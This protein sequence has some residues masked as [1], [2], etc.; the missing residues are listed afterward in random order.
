M[1]HLLGLDE[2]L[3][4]Q[5]GAAERAGYRT[6]NVLFLGVV[7]L[8]VVSNGYSGYLLTGSWWGVPW[9]AL[10]MGFIHFSVLRISLITLMTRPLTEKPLPNSGPTQENPPAVKAPR[11]ALRLLP[12]L[13]MAAM[14]RLVFTGLIAL[15]ICMPFAMLVFHDEAIA[16]EESYRRQLVM[17]ET[18]GDQDL[19]V[20]MS[21]SYADDKEA[22][23]PFVVMEQL[24][25]I[26]SYRMLVL[27]LVSLVFL[28]SLFLAR[29]RYGKKYRYSLLCRDAMRKEISLDYN[30]ALEQS[31]YLLGKRFPVFQKRLE[32][33]TVFADPPFNTTL[34]NA[35]GN[36]FG[37][38]SEF[39]NHLRSL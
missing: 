24:W 16:L 38:R 4:K 17:K 13:N 27:F 39:L 29:L 36:T 1:N 33:A 31:Q 11:A 7:A 28:P 23:Y 9:L 34:R 12:R 26:S 5:V 8:S 6:V 18:A 20:G 14:V 30:E 10:L 2:D 15:T 22:H 35:S 19:Q 32:D 25:K 3:L 21:M 37:S